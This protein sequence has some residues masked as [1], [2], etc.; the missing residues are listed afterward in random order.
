MSNIQ[1]KI[2]LHL[3]IGMCDGMFSTGG[4][5]CAHLRVE[6]GWF[7]IGSSGERKARSEAGSIDGLVPLWRHL[8]KA[9]NPG[10]RGH[11]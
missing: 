5:V 6:S 1:L 10:G 7:E 4:D 2:A 8:L 3:K 11:C 9:L